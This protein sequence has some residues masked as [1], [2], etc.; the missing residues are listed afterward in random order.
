MGRG[1]GCSQHAHVVC[2]K[3]GHACQLLS[4]SPEP[5]CHLVPLSQMGW[6]HEG[7]RVGGGSRRTLTEAAN[8]GAAPG[9]TGLRGRPLRCQAGLAASLLCFALA[10]QGMAHSR[11][12]RFRSLWRPR[13]LGRGWLWGGRWADDERLIRPHAPQPDAFFTLGVHWPAPAPT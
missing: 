6:R 9:L 10:A 7:D 11:I 1:A 3:P 8:S 13:T 4:F 12:Q 5:W 2:A